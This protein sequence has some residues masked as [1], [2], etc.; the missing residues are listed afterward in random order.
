METAEESITD[1]G[2][3]YIPITKSESLDSILTNIL[4]IALSSD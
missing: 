2:S 3:H 4:D 1:V